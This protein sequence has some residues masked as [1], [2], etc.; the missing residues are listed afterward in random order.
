MRQGLARGKEVV[1][2]LQ[3]Y[4]VRLHTGTD[5]AG[6]PFVVPGASLHEEL[7]HF[8][9]AGLTAEQAWI[10]A[11]SAPAESLGVPGLGRVAAGMLADL[12]IFRADPTRDIAALSTLEAVVAQGRLYTRAAL[13]DALER[14][15]RAFESPLYERLSM[16]LTEL[17]MRQMA[18]QGGL[19]IE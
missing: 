11:T 18:R 4:G 8:V 2:Q 17:G 9:D 14:H 12:A 5:T 7:G 19:R 16:A 10:A 13:Y 15:R 1:R 3:L 6:M